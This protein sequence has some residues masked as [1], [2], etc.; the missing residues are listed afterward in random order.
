MSDEPFAQ[1]AI[2]ELFGHQRIAGKVTEAAIGGCALLR[3]DVPAVDDQP[4]FT[5]YYGQGAIYSLTV[6]EEAVARSAAARIRPT[7]VEIYLLP[8]TAQQYLLTAPDEAQDTD[9]D[10]WWEMSD[11]NK[12]H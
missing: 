11:A 7:P 1:W 2:L 3:V 9:D 5:R 12:D 4:G 10:D 6:V 8:R